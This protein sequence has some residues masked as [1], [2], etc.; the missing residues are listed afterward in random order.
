MADPTR[1]TKNWAG[2]NTNWQDSHKDVDHT[3]TLRESIQHNIIIRAGTNEGE[4]SKLALADCRK[5][6]TLGLQTVICH[7]LQVIFCIFDSKWPPSKSNFIWDPFYK[8]DWFTPPESR[9]WRLQDYFFTTT[10]KASDV[11]LLQKTSLNKI[12]SVK[13]NWLAQNFCDPLTLTSQGYPV[14]TRSKTR[15]VGLSQKIIKHKIIFR[16]LIMEF[17]QEHLTLSPEGY[18]FTLTKHKSKG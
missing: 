8:K 2:P 17:F 4:V 12:C 15:V 9:F 10:S 5:E 11:S 13:L 1:A 7:G 3:S 16:I 14:P 18:L 6:Y